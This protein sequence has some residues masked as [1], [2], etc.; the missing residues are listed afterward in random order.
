MT[1]FVVFLEIQNSWITYVI[2]TFLVHFWYIFVFDTLRFCLNYFLPP[3]F[4]PF[5]GHF[6]HFWYCIKPCIA[7]NTQCDSLCYPPFLLR[8]KFTVSCNLFLL[9]PPLAFHCAVY[10]RASCVR[11][12]LIWTF[13]KIFHDFWS[14]SVKNKEKP[15][16]LKVRLR[17]LDLFRTK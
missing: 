9:W 12:C 17:L 10:F 16:F 11:K 1:I 15:P 13:M 4:V 5:F 2:F 8:W 14:S 6:P 7:K 3:N